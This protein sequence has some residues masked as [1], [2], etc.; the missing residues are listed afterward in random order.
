MENKQQ[1]QL[2]ITDISCCF[3]QN[4]PHST[5]MYTRSD[6]RS[7]PFRYPRF[8]ELGNDLASWD[9]SVSLRHDEQ[10]RST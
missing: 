5:P 9:R 10:Q 4:Q 2:W 6:T 7:F 8:A 3:V 1:A